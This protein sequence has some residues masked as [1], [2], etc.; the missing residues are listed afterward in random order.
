MTAGHWEFLLCLCLLAA[1][2]IAM[3]VR[4][5]RRKKRQKEFIQRQK[6]KGDEGERATEV[7]L[8]RV[9]GCKKVLRQVYVPKEEAG[10]SELDLVMIHEKGIFVVE[11][12]Y[13]GGRIYG[14]ERKLYWLQVFKGGKR[15]LFYSPVKQNQ[16]HIRNLKRLLEG[17]VPWETPY[18][19]VIIFNGAGKL[20]RAAVDPDTAVVASG[21]K[22]KR[23]LKR[24][25]RR[26]KRV[27]TRG[28]IDEISRFL[29]QRAKGSKRVRKQH[30]KQFEKVRFP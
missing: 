18:V 28:Q 13:Y 27:L 29:D 16:T 6:K 22:A 4:R 10:T 24:R 17:R 26:M 19:S 30:E 1:A 5:S 7:L 2:V 3:A 15:R 21:K 14:D 11:N 23:R 9:R 8:N 12:K 20:K 25:M